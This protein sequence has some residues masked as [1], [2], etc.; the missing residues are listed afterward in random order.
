MIVLDEPEVHLHPN[1]QLKYAEIITLLVKNNINCNRTRKYKV[2]HYSRNR[3]GRRGNETS[4]PR[5]WTLCS[6]YIHITTA[7]DIV[8]KWTIQ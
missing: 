6:S 8:I 1:W 5:A 2:Q 7:E 3:D 4:M